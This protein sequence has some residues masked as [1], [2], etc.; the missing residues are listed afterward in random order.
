[1]LVSQHYEVLLLLRRAAIMHSEF[2]PLRPGCCTKMCYLAE[3][4]YSHDLSGAT[5]K[6]S[7]A[8]DTDEMAR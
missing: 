5:G 2:L 4:C 7:G 6:A 1:M 8:P 3:E